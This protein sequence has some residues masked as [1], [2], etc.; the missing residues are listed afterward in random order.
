MQRRCCVLIC[1][2]DESPRIRCRGLQDVPLSSTTTP[3]WCLFSSYDIVHFHY[4]YVLL[5]L[6]PTQVWCLPSIPLCLE[7][8]PADVKAPPTPPRSPA[9]GLFEK[10]DWVTRRR[11]AWN[12]SIFFFFQDWCASYE[13]VFL[14]V[15][16]FFFFWSHPLIQLCHLP[17]LSMLLQTFGPPQSLTMYPL[18]T[19]SLPFD[20][21]CFYKSPMVGFK[22]H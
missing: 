11:T 10:A 20:K 16:F 7:R 5:H 21:L 17:P 8:K 22:T 12:F 18:Y 14:N 9:C 4:P 3:N 13:D 19:S 1:S 6:Y 15:F 2:G